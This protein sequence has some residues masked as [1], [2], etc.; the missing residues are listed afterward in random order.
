MGKLYYICVIF[1]IIF[2]LNIQKHSTF[3]AVFRNGFDKTNRIDNNVEIISDEKEKGRNPSPEPIFVGVSTGNINTN[4]TYSGNLT[5]SLTNYSTSVDQILSAAPSYKPQVNSSS[6][7]ATSN[8]SLGDIQLAQQDIQQALSSASVPQ[9]IQHALSSASAQQDIQ[10]A[11]SSASAQQ[12]IQQALSSASAQQ[13]IQQALSSASAPQDIQQALSSASVPQDIAEEFL[14]QVEA[15]GWTPSET[16]SEITVPTLLMEAS[17]NV[18]VAAA[19]SA[20]HTESIYLEGDHENPAIA[21]VLFGSDSH[22]LV[23]GS[24]IQGTFENGTGS[25]HSEGNIDG[26][27]SQMYNIAMMGE[28]NEVSVA[29]SSDAAGSGTL[30]QQALSDILINDAQ[31]PQ[32][33]YQTAAEEYLPE[34]MPIEEEQVFQQSSYPVHGEAEVE[35][36]ENLGNQ[37]EDE[38]HLPETEFQTSAETVDNLNGQAEDEQNLPETEFQTSEET[39]ENFNGQLEDEQNFQETSEFQLPAEAVENFN[40]QLEDE[41]TFQETSELQLPA[42]PSEDAT[43]DNA[44][45]QAEEEQLSLD[46]P[47]YA[48]ETLN[49]QLEQETETE[50]QSDTIA[51]NIAEETL[52]EQLE[53]ETETEVQGDTIANNIAEELSQNS[54]INFPNP[55]DTN[56]DYDD[57]DEDQKY[58]GLISAVLQ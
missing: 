56:I 1:L 48:E 47:G 6:S 12:D 3:G 49:E 38:Q 16:D 27:S 46:S 41:Q 26:G 57:N 20:S 23:G 50:V 42:E 4:P 51:N 54:D 40:G 37:E 43:N 58:D 30:T 18:G 52:N 39:V 13:D 21:N 22:Y 45:E 2:T 55:S 7:F 19:V 8:G 17:I 11:L 36:V 9:D 24:I 25:Q 28:H 14:S 32:N 5:P 35:A 53:Q 44:N 29:G 33:T 10:Q 15:G 31:Q 34:P